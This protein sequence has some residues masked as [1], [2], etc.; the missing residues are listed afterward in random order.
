MTNRMGVGRCIK[1]PAKLGFDSLDEG[2]ATRVK[3]RQHSGFVLN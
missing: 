1:G 3:D 2:Y